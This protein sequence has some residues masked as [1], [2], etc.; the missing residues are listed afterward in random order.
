MNDRIL[1]IFPSY[2][3]VLALAAGTW[4][5]CHLDSYFISRAPS[6]IDWAS[7]I[8]IVPLNLYKWTGQDRFTLIPQAW[9]LGLELQFYLVAPFLIGIIGD[10]ARLAIGLGS[11]AWYISCFLSNDGDVWGY[12]LLSG[13]L[14]FFLIGIVARDLPRRWSFLT[15]GLAASFLLVLTL[16]DMRAPGFAREELIGLMLGLGIVR[17]AGGWRRGSI[18][19]YLGG[20]SYPFF[21]TH[22][23]PIWWLQAA[24]FDVEAIDNEPRLI[25]FVVLTTTVLSIT[26]YHVVEKP[27]SRLRRAWRRRGR[28]KRHLNPGDGLEAPV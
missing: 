22:F 21:L 18:D 28:F 10:R 8:F 26:L 13:A 9:S 19:N 14:L 24:G 23:L 15:H 12:R 16:R 25:C 5:Y 17:L 1:R 27:V 2:F 3:F 7:N 11:V 20:L 4:L 6:T